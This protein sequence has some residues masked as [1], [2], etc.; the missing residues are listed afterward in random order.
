[1]PDDLA[2]AVG[3][4][5]ARLTTNL[6]VRV[7][8]LWPLLRP[9]LRSMFDRLAAGWDS[10]RGPDH[11]AA[12]EEG[13]AGLDP[14]RRA[15]DVGTGTGLGAFA[16]AQRFPE[17][18]VVGVDLAGDMVAEAQR[19]TPP[20]LERRVRFETADAA[21]LPFPDASFDLV[22]LAN[23]IPFFDELERVLEDAG[24]LLIA[25]TWG[26]ET[27]IYVAPERLRAE[28]E[29]RGFSEFA[30]SSAGTGTALIARKLARH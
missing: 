12:F 11:L 29:A 14:P 17:A 19:K 4:R 25:F 28:L 8:A 27:P 2:R 24:T 7:P 22:A 21:R 15:L 5:F 18:E 20:E 26:S 3:Q 13:L 23:M 10:R 16:I 1:L 9:F 6:V 30:E